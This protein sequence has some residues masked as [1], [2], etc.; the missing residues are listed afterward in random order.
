MT[1]SV[2][3]STTKSWFKRQ[4]DAALECRR[5]WI[6]GAVLLFTYGIY[7]G[8]TSGRI[9]N[10]EAWFLQAMRRLAGGEVLYKDIFFN[11]PPLSA[12]LTSSL[13]NIFGAELLLI[14]LLAS[15]CFTA[16]GLFLLL[17]LKKLGLGKT[18]RALA[19]LAYLAYTPSRLTAVGSLYSPLAYMLLLAT[20]LMI[21]SWLPVGLGMLESAD[22]GGR[23]RL[24]A[25][26]ILCGL[27]FVTK[28][29]IGVYVFLGVSLWVVAYSVTIRQK[30][31]DLLI[32]TLPILTGFVGTSLLIL[33]PTVLTGGF[34]RFL[35]YGFLNRANYIQAAQISYASQVTKLLRLV[36]NL[37]DWKDLLLTYWQTQFLLPPVAFGVLFVAWFRSKSHL[38]RM[39]TL[40]IL[41]NIISFVGAFPRFDRAHI[42]P[43]LPM[44]LVSIA[45]GISQFQ[46]VIK[47][48]LVSLIYS[49]CIL[50]LSL[51]IIALIIR[52]IR[53]I[54]R[55]THIVSSLPHFRAQL[56]PK[57]IVQ[58]YEAVVDKIHTT[59]RGAPLFFL[60][61]SASTLY[62]LTDRPNL[63][64]YDYPLVTAFGSDGQEQ[65]IKQVQNGEIS[66]VCF[67]TLAKRPLNPRLLEEFVQRHML[68]VQGTQICMLYRSPA[69]DMR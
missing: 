34:E 43:T 26:G 68:P 66:W 53:W 55:G 48:R 14:K 27:T 52:P 31:R 30:P 15:G 59:T 51:G 6:L 40:L 63:T 37:R 18:P 5:G 13:I 49:L 20:F 36:N 7:T 3:I 8:L 29:N 54:A 2:R 67:S 22:P 47:P 41:F 35:E 65:V 17:I 32:F 4:L 12:Y 1:L 24:L 11:V 45:W 21:L 38:R 58:D 42:I 16:T 50:W 9:A 39:A 19:L 33:I 28:H 44:T 10:G 25:L 64:P 62:L 69:Q 60:T 57:T 46:T 23:R 56:L 61:P